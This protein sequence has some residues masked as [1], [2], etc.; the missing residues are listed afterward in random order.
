MPPP[1]SMTRK[2]GICTAITSTSLG[3]PGDITTAR[4]GLAPSVSA[5][6]GPARKARKLADAST[7][8]CLL[9][10]IKRGSL[11]VSLGLVQG[12]VEHPA[13]SLDSATSQ[14][15]HSAM[16]HPSSMQQGGQHQ[17]VSSRGGS[18]AEDIFPPANKGCQGYTDGKKPNLLALA[19][20]QA[21]DT[22]VWPYTPASRIRVIVRCALLKTSRL[23]EANASYRCSI[24]QL[25][26]WQLCAA[27]SVLVKIADCMAMMQEQRDKSAGG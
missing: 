19:Q 17:S 22:D 20:E 4:L 18:T 2:P 8:V 12:C 6:E 24:E 11:F 1:C 16:Q 9:F 27:T 14:H 7:R 13:S 21:L 5:C 3:L 15:S 25:R 26:T 23:Y 10:A